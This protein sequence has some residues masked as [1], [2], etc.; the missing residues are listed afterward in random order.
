MFLAWAVLH[1]LE[2]DLHREHSRTDL[3]L[4]RSRK[5][6]GR[7]FLF[8]ACDGKFWED[9][10]SEEGNGFARWYYAPESGGYGPYV[11]DYEA[12]LAAGLPTLYHVADTWENFDKIARVIDS[13]FAEWNT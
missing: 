3:L 2:G 12:I 6:T 7:E 4:L 9:D 10:L 13:R 8:R 1:G 5:I 11:D